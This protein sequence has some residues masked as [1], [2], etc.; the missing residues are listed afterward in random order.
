MVP[1][2]IVYTSLCIRIV[3]MSDCDFAVVLNENKHKQAAVIKTVSR[4]QWKMMKSSSCCLCGKKRSVTLAHAN[5]TPLIDG[6]SPF[7]AVHRT[8]SVR[9]VVR[10]EDVTASPDNLAAFLMF[11]ETLTSH[12]TATIYY[13]MSRWW[14]AYTHTHI[15]EGAHMEKINHPTQLARRA[16]RA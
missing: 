4:C 11:G 6:W 3:I 9:T 1:F 13:L 8:M 7:R 15:C 14:R 2:S 16:D 12:L 5:V 10:E